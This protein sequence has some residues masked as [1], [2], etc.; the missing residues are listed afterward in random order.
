MTAAVH[1]PC[2]EGAT[3]LREDSRGIM[4]DASQEVP[5]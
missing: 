2:A 5:E 1:C 3:E 4:H